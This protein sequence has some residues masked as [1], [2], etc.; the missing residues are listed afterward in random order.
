MNFQKRK[1]LTPV[2]FSGFACRM[3]QSFMSLNFGS[4]SVVLT[5]YIIVYQRNLI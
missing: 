2:V 1:S 5:V 3:S 4:N